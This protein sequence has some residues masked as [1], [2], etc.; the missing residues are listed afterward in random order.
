MDEADFMEFYG[1][2]TFKNNLLCQKEVLGEVF[3]AVIADINIKI[4]FP[5]Y[6]KDTTQERCVGMENPL[7][8]PKGKHNLTRGGESLDWGSPMDYPAGNSIVKAVVFL[9]ECEEYLIEENAQKLYAAIKSWGKKFLDYCD[10][11]T[12]KATMDFFCVDAETCTLELV[13]KKYISTARETK[14]EV[15]LIEKSKCLTKDH[16]CKAIDFASSSKEILFEYQ[17][18]SSAYNFKN[19][20]Q[21]RQAIVDACSAVEICLNRQIEKYCLKIGLNSDV[22][23]EKYK[24]LGDKF[25]LIEKIDKTFNV[26]NPFGRIV[27]PRNG[28][29]HKNTFP[30]AKTTMEL[31]NAVEECMNLY[32]V[33]FY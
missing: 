27:S 3:D 23:F 28:V 10:L 7:E 19:E 24:S 1:V 26:K 15:S 32:N 8:P 6:P 25:K 14:F 13:H 16:I 22:L 5:C 2:L 12:K 17:L 21:Y 30:D 18:L 9:I 29:V 33:D 20:K 31:L 4:C 11:C